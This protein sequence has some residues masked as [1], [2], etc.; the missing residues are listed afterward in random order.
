MDIE[1][2]IKGGVELSEWYPKK[3]EVFERKINDMIA[4]MFPGVGGWIISPELTD[5]HQEEEAAREQIKQKEFNRTLIKVLAKPEVQE[6]IR[7][8][9]TASAE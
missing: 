8:I 5:R 2:V 9:A 1:I 6:M 4:E 3:Y 7:N